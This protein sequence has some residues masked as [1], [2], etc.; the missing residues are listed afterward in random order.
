M[1]REQIDATCQWTQVPKGEGGMGALSRPF[2]PARP[3]EELC[4]Q[5]SPG[6]LHPS[7]L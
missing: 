4:T 6:R 7:V 2:S 1:E 5:P 3:S